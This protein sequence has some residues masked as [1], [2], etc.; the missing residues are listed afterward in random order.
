MATGIFSTTRIAGEGIALAIVSA[1]LTA[2][3]NWKL[4]AGPD[5][6]QAAQKLATG[7]IASA[8][9]LLGPVS[10]E[11]VLQTYGEAF[12]QLLQI[13]AEITLVTALAIFIVMRIPDK[14]VIAA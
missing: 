7:N 12:G 5:V 8:M 2:L 3:L 9:G 11:A 1:L 4:G 13:L 10:P 6:A 14:A